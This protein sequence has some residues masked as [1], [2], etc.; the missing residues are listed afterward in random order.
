MFVF[1]FQ[2]VLGQGKLSSEGEKAIQQIDAILQRLNM[3]G[4]AWY[5]DGAPQELWLKRA[6]VKAERSKY[7]NEFK[8]SAAEKKELDDAFN[9]LAKQTAGRTHIE[10]YNEEAYQKLGSEVPVGSKFI[11]DQ[12]I[13]VNEEISNYN[14]DDHIYLVEGKDA[15]WVLRAIS[16]KEREKWAKDFFKSGVSGKD[17][18]YSELDA[19]AATASTKIPLFTPNSSNFSMRNTTEEE[20][21][22]T[23]LSNLA[24]LKIHKIGLADK[25]WQIV[26]NDL[27]IPISRYKQGYLWVRD[28]KDD[29]SY[30]HLY[31]INIIQDYQGGS[32]Y[33]ASYAKFLNDV[34]VG[35]P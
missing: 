25:T 27:D 21:M 30:C 2:T 1:S 11:L 14:P 7:Y 32:K 22:K 13:K 8:P 15:E 28:S 29:H 24:S 18:F 16:K 12:I 34:I 6:F 5:S 9:N 35:C 20:L 10:A 31:Q 17:Q 26:K 33:G 4:N 19:L 3:N 23:K